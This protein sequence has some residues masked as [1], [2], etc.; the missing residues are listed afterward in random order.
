MLGFADAIFEIAFVIRHA[1][2][3]VVFLAPK[4]IDDGELFCKEYA[5]CKIAIGRRG[6]RFRMGQNLRPR[7][8]GKVKFRPVPFEIRFIGE[9]D[10]IRRLVL[11]KKLA[12]SAAFQIGDLLGQHRRLIALEQFEKIG[13]VIEV[14]LVDAAKFRLG[15]FDED[16]EL[17][18]D[19]FQ[20]L[21]TQLVV[22]RRL[23]AGPFKHQRQA[24]VDLVRVE[25]ACSFLGKEFP[26]NR[27][28]QLIALRQPVC[29]VVVVRELIDGV[30]QVIGLVA[31]NESAETERLEQN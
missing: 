11:R 1:R 24:M 14:R 20:V 23:A 22:G 4:V 29:L 17:V 31:G 28:Q 8:S 12:V 26:Q 7:H 16:T 30:T 6:L 13:V 27:G 19:R 5:E 15:K 10:K 21:G 25:R 3:F 2:L 18:V 9:K